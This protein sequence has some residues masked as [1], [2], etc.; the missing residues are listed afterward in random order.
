MG[1]N[2]IVSF[3]L[4]RSSVG[5]FMLIPVKSEAD[6]IKAHLWRDLDFFN[7][8][9]HLMP[10][11]GCMPLLRKHLCTLTVAWVPYLGWMIC[12]CLRCLRER[13]ASL[14]LPYSNGRAKND[15][16]GYFISSNNRFD[17]TC[18]QWPYGHWE[19]SKQLVHIIRLFSSALY[20]LIFY[21]PV[22]SQAIEWKYPKRQQRQTWK[23]SQ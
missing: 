21:W 20:S 18:F 5:G 11:K 23:P 19:E 16:P 2:Y 3:P 8:V 10:T 6:F 7:P 4:E 22:Y 9:F 13:H 14:L 15:C 17:W 1:R 12:G